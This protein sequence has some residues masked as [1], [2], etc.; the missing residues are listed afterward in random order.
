MTLPS[1]PTIVTYPDGETRGTAVVRH[2]ADQGDGTTVVLLDVTPCHP[3]DAG[4]PD[5]GPDRATIRHNGTE[6]AVIDCVVAATDGTELFTGAEIPVKKGTEGWTFAV[7]HIVDDGAALAEGDE[8]DVVVDAGYRTALS[9]GHTACHVA[10]L[11]LNKAMAGRWKKKVREDG[12]GTPDFDG[13]AIDVSKIV[14]NG[15][16]DT[17]RLGKS[18]R[19]KGFNVDGLQEDLPAIEDAVNAAL[20]EWVGTRAAVRIDRNGETLTD[21]RFW[22]CELPEQTVSIPCGGTHL[23]SLAEVSSLQVSLSTDDV[24]GTTVLRMETTATPAP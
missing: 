15:S 10:S 7:A 3:V 16:V 20:V 11:A 17:Y 13:L 23:K 2:L 21:R 14:E 5:Q 18:L 24:D 4:W 8:V 6:L 12:L 19:R 22:V 1:E 9:T